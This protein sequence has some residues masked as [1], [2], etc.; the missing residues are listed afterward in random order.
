MPSLFASADRKSL[1]ERLERFGPGATRQWGT[2]G[3]AQALT[4]CSIAL[5]AAVGDRPMKQ[6]FIGKILAPFVRG[7]VLGERPFKRNSPTDPTF[8]VSEEC[9]LVV[10]KQRLL[11]LIVRF[12]EGGPDAAA[13][14]EH[15]FFGKLTGA[16]WGTL[17]WKHVDHHLRQFGG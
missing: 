1:T 9:D 11:A 5:E 15:A 17:M 14:Q 12:A 8:V 6:K 16:G 10:E 3:P 4:H 7:M 13:R 2:M